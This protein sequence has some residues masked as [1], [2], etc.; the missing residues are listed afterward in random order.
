VTAIHPATSPDSSSVISK[1][2]RDDE[3][4]LATLALRPEAAESS[5]S[6]FGDDRWDLAPAIFRENAPHALT[7]VNFAALADPMQRLTAKEFIWARLNEPSPCPT[8]ARMAPTI[9]RATLTDLRFFMQFVARHA[10]AFAMHMV[11]QALL[12]AYLAE[13]RRERGRTAERVA[14][15]LDVPIELDRYSPFLTLG[16]FRCRPWRGRPAARV[17]GLPPRPMVAEN[18]TP[19]IPEPVIA[20]LLRW[21]LKYVD[22]FAADIFAARAELDRLEQAIHQSDS[23]EVPAAL[24]DRLDVYIGRRC[25]DGR[26][27]P[28]TAFDRG[29]RRK[30]QNRST[31]M[32]EPAINFHLI[33][34]QLGCDKRLLISRPT[35]RRRLERAIERL[36]GEIGGMDSTIAV[37]PDTGLPWR[38]RF[39]ERS[40]AEEER[41]LQAAAYVICAYLTGMRDSELQAMRVGCWSVGRSADGIIERHRIKSITYKARETSGEEAEWVTI[42]P[43][44]RAI[45]VV[46]R[47]TMQQRE[48]RATDTIWQTLAMNNGNMTVLRGGVIHLI[49]GLRDHL[50]ARSP[51]GPAIPHVEGGPWWFTPRQFRRTLAWYIANRPFGTVAGKIQYKHASI[52]MFEGYSG[53]SPSGF[54]REVEQERAL[55]QIDDVVEHYEEAIKRGLPP[56]GP[57]AARLRNEFARIRDE[58]GDLPGRIV[59]AQ[60]LRSMLGHLGRTLHVGLLADCFFDPDTALCLDR[61]N[62]TTDRSAP[63][64]SHCRPDRCPNACVTRRHLAPWQASIAEAEHLLRDRRL[65]SLQRQV[66]TED[67]ERKRRLIAPLLEGPP[68]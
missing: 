61:K 26:G 41:M 37:D 20:A 11:D 50:D 60:R 16:G 56:A 63:A 30:P 15:L 47:L 33:A 25:V 23:A 21:S 22:L 17:A 39:D 38:E 12:D 10:G 49:N 8:R 27:I 13:L 59:D 54:R 66:L 57:A 35:L 5:L 40:I 31:G 34:L 3:L 36:G 24:I 67:N 2:R 1:M 42:A 9:A 53:S 48:I 29:G 44:A 65:S 32:L 19:R 18:R 43:V 64:L 51:E 62:A 52:A 7:A 28:V 6:R 4:V 14:H 46:E 45:E 68:E 55:G 58:L